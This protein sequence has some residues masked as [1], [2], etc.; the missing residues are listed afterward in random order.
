MAKE[1]KQCLTSKVNHILRNNNIDKST[2]NYDN[3]SATINNISAKLKNRQLDLIH[4]NKKLKFYSSF[5]FDDKKSEFLDHV[6][7]PLHRKIASKFRLGNH[8][9]QIEAGRFTIP[10]TPANI[11]YYPHCKHL[12]E[13]EIHFLLKCTLYNDSRNEFF[14]KLADSY[15]IFTR[16]SDAEKI[17]FIFSSTDANVSRLCASF[18]Y[19]ATEKRHKLYS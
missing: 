11:R 9:L 1:N 5:K 4:L 17:I 12:V 10:K 14:V 2:I 13:D 19:K 16:L 15:K 6:K 3:P 7:N 8:K 18:L